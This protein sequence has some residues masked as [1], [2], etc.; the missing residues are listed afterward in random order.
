MS[1]AQPVDP[2]PTWGVDDGVSTSLTFLFNGDVHP[3]VPEFSV[4]YAGWTGGQMVLTGNTSWNAALNGRSGVI[5]FG[6]GANGA[7]T[8]TLT[9]GNF[10]SLS[11][12][13]Q[14]F[15]QFDRRVTSGTSVENTQATDAG[16]VISDL[17]VVLVPLANGW[18]RVTQTFLISSQPGSQTFQFAIT[19][20]T[21]GNGVGLD[22]I[23]VHTHSIIPTPAAGV[24]LGL[25]A[26]VG[27]RRRR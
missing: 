20:D 3:P 25:G 18:E 26:L 24:V 13:S 12:I 10:Q 21:S 1:H 17:Q 8:L 4:G 14:V 23:Y 19:S 7:G 16:S 11:L 15:L 27:M 22:N 6:P 5:G 2:P 9:V